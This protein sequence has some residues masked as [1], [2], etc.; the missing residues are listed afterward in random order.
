[1]HRFKLLSTFL[2]SS[3]IRTMEDAIAAWWDAWLDLWGIMFDAEA[4]KQWLAA[5][6]E[7]LDADMI[8]AGWHGGFAASSGGDEG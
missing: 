4:R 1:M 2:P 7:Q 5:Q 8:D 3:A 6:R